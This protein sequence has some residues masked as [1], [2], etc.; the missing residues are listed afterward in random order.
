[1]TNMICTRIKDLRKQVGITQEDLGN[2]L[3]IQKSAVAKYENGRI[4]S[5]AP[6]MVE[7]FASAL[8]TT[9]TYLT[10]KLET[11][12]RALDIEIRYRE[13]G[14]V[15]LYDNG[16]HLVTY[17]RENWTELQERDDF[18]VVWSDIMRAKEKPTPASEDGLSEEKRKLIELVKREM[19]DED[20]RRLRVIVDQVILARGE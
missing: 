20:V 15:D 12:L 6:D 17:S 9:A 11:D 16:E 3:G 8:G 5:V 14:P 18:K 13:R 10:G 19:S 1:M 4:K 2:K 7:A